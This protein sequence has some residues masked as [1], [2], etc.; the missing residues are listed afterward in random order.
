MIV[1]L[2]TRAHDYTHSK[3][4]GNGRVEIERVDYGR[5]LTR[6]RIVNATY[7]FTDLDRLNFWELE[8]AGRIYRQL[9]KA[10]MRV[11]NDPA[12]VRQR[13]SLL[14]ALRA[15]GLN[16]FDTWRVED[17]GRPR[18]DE[19]P[20]FLRT[21]SAHRGNLTDLLQ[22]P[23]ELDAA[24]A[25]ALGDG[26]PQSE[27]LI[28][29]YC[30]EPVRPGLFRKLSV[31]RVGDRMLTTLCVHD[32][33]WTAKYGEQGI[34][35]AELYDEELRFVRDNVWGEALRAAFDVACIEYGRADFALVDGKPQVYEI[36][37]NPNYGPVI[38][39]P[40][41]QR[42]EAGRRV[43]QALLDALVAVDNPLGGCAVRIGGWP[44]EQQRSRDR[45]FL[46]PRWTP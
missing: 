32:T 10:G 28:I 31:Y 22:T 38:E 5:F 20:V 16:R 1:F 43:E 27:L 13:F 21:A 8:L 30:A 19:Y 6:R 3:L 40:F 25:T 26:I 18:S 45:W 36:N 24:I 35:G 15:A 29:Q 17:V 12:R 39:H 33:R 34:A 4:Q 41:P 23:A 9:G 42:I 7:V 37:T 44:L 14:R 46:A 2:T 11:L